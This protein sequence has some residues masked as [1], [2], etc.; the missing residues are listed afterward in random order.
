MTQRHPSLQNYRSAE[1]IVHDDEEE[2][3]QTAKPER[4]SLE[5]LQQQLEQTNRLCQ[6]LLGDQAASQMARLSVSGN[7]ACMFFK[8]MDTPAR[9]ATLS[10]MFFLPM[11]PANSSFDSRLLF[12]KELDALKNKLKVAKAV[13]L[14]E[15]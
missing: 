8:K 7:F 6:T 4:P 12:R 3:D 1:E 15:W 13:Y 14:K 11:L 9:L 10:K 5:M 2:I